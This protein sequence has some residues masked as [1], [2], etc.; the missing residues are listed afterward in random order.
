MG[1]GFP[2]LSNTKG[3]T[4]VTNGGHPEYAGCTQTQINLVSSAYGLRIRSLY[5]ATRVHVY[6]VGGALPF[7]G[8]KITSIGE[9]V[10][11]GLKD[12]KET[13]IVVVY[14]SYPYAAS[15][16]DAALYSASGAIN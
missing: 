1:N 11:G 13:R 16:I 4:S 7:Q 3:F 5:A 12:V 9:I 8:Y 2:N 10:S 15:F 14:K 6:P